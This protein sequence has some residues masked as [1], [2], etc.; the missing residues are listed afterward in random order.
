MTHTHTIGRALP[1]RI[2]LRMALAAT[3]AAWGLGACGDTAG[4]GSGDVGVSADADATVGPDLAADVPAPTA[5]A[6]V[7]TLLSPEADSVWKLGE[8][9][10]VSARV[11]DADD[12][13]T[14]LTFVLRAAGV[15]VIAEGAI[16]ASSW[17]HAV[18]S[19]NAGSHVLTLEV[20]DP[21]GHVGVASVA[22]RVNRPPEGSTQVTISPAAPTTSDALTATVSGAAT[23]PDGQVVTYRYAWT[24]DGVPA[25]ISQA[26]VPASATARGQ[27]WQV[28]AVPSDGDHEGEV[29]EA[30]VVIGNAPPTIKSATLLPSAVATDGTL[31]CSASGWADA[32]GDAEGYRFEWY[33]DGKLV[34]NEA[35]ESLDGAWF[36][37][38]QTVRCRVAPWDG[39]DAGKALDS[40]TVPVL[41]TPPSV[42][43]VEIS[44]PVGTAKTTFSCTAQGISDP[45]PGDA[46]AVQT[47]W[48]VDGVEQ[49]G[50]TSASYT[51]VGHKRGTEVQCKVV[52]LS[53]A[54]AGSPV[55]SAVVVLANAAPSVGAVI[56]TPVPATETTGVQCL[57]SDVTDP[58]GDEVTLQVTW[59]V[60]G[61][62]VAGVTGAILS[63][64]HYAKGQTVTCSVVPSDGADEGPSVA[65]KFGTVIANEAPT[66]ESV[67]LGPPGAKGT[68]TLQCTPAGFADPDGDAAGFV[69]AWSVDGTVIAG[70]SGATLSGGGLSKGAEVVCTVTPFDGAAAGPPVSSL[71]L[72]I[73]NSAPSLVSASVTPLEGGKLTTFT[74][75]P[76]GH[77]DPDA[78][79]LKVY[80][81][82]WFVDGVVVAGQTGASFV[83]G[84]G[85]ASGGEVRCEATPSDGAAS[86]EP[87][88]SGPALLKNQAPTV[89]S[90]T[91]GPAGAT[92]AT[93]L[94]CAANGLADADGDP[95][96]VS[97]QWTVNDALLT[98]QSGS[99]LT[100]GVAKKGQTVRCLAVPS[101]GKL[102]GA[103]A[104]SPPLVIGNAAPKLAGAAV[105]PGSGTTATTFTC[106]AQGAS[107]PDGDT[108]AVAWRWLIGSV[109]VAGA[110]DASFLPG[111]AASGG[112]TLRCEATP[113]DGTA[114]GPAVLS[115]A[116][117]LEGPP[118]DNQPPTV[119]SA[120]I[121]PSTALTTTAL[122]CS[123]AGAV[124]P[125]GLTVTLGYAWTKN[126]VP[127]A[128]QTAKTLPASAHKKGDSVTCT[129]TP[130]DGELY[131]AAKAS[132][133]VV[134]GNSAP[135]I[136]EVV[137]TPQE[138]ATGAALTCTVTASDPDG[139]TLTY[140]YQWLLDSKIADGQ[141]AAT[142]AAGTTQACEPWTCLARVSDGALFSGF[143][144]DSVATPS[145]GGSGAFGWFQHHSFD[146]LAGATPKKL[147]AFLSIEVA[148]TRITLP[149]A[150]FPYTLTKVRFL[151]AAQSYEVIVYS[152]TFGAVGAVLSKQTVAG[153][154]TYQEVTLPAPV[155]FGTPQSFWLGLGSKSDGMS[156]RGDGS[157]PADATSNEIYGCDFYFLGECFTV[158]AWKP[159]DSFVDPTGD[160]A[161]DPFVTF[162][163]LIIDAG[164]ETGA[165]CP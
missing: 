89:G 100:S 162:G 57:A 77:S 80:G 27:T 15:G 76:S 68:D 159:F 72:V 4:G 42:A 96:T 2:A 146:P 107:D 97:Y 11:T 115:A 6:P 145:G 95:V 82:R 150:A 128:G 81:F 16:T 71:T 52:P 36:D 18:D 158:F 137:V 59:T 41:D 161:T 101:D 33:V 155:E 19:L 37:K 70:A 28:R 83:P 132:A 85:A 108:I 134:I 129:V 93:T 25:Q 102:T 144:E 34:A 127:I 164:G 43:G 122:T 88:L 65:S 121:T 116:V 152:D 112:D 49:P 163:D 69:Y 125:E 104:Q 105:S 67:S 124:D 7:V 32:D 26:Q 113:S 118:P 54:V 140:A 64:E 31:T 46:T 51:P 3:L 99:A 66:L 61:V 14:S 23:D 126:G 131:G 17:E 73:A 142:L 56:V 12:P 30:S 110:V 35:G 5:D 55:L 22:L 9:I 143:D 40:A 160:P 153:N 151:S 45:D 60:N 78:G 119:A 1:L 103:P 139:D 133:P 92:T 21:A 130:F 62:V 8:A 44:P 13:V 50:T 53:G 47:I 38:G 98:G 138:P 75:V 148:A 94:V 24:R 156:I 141:T 149:A 90:V 154:G 48:V 111:G 58:D 63:G 79:D 147:S 87:V 120:S 165:G 74:C 157:P 39:L 117:T 10:L 106:S 136:S 91:V 135:V 84:V 29:G 109:V 20:R 86:G 123:A 114:T